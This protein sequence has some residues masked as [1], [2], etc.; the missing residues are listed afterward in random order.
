MRREIN[1]VI[2]TPKQF[3]GAPYGA[4]A[5]NLLVFAVF[6]MITMATGSNPILLVIF[7]GVIHGSLIMY[8]IRE[9]DFTEVIMAW[10]HSYGGTQN[11]VFEKGRVY[12]P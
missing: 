8:G 4:A 11:I 2:L 5:F 10:N 7:S 12:H 9:P 3:L 1:H 6:L